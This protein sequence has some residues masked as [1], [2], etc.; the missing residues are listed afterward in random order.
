[1]VLVRSVARR[2]V[3]RWRERFE[4]EFLGGGACRRLAVFFFFLV[5]ID[6]VVVVDV[7]VNECSSSWCSGGGGFILLGVFGR[8]GSGFCL[9]RFSVGS[10]VFIVGVG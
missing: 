10:I 9:G 8:F 3:R 5:P 6:V 4:L 7:C 2:S 1:M